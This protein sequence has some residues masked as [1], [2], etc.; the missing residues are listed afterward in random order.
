MLRQLLQ[1]EFLG[2]CLEDAF[3]MLVFLLLIKGV[4]QF[5][6]YGLGQILFKLRKDERNTRAKRWNQLKTQWIPHITTSKQDL[7][8]K[9]HQI[10][11]HKSPQGHFIFV[12]PWW[13]HFL[14][15]EFGNMQSD[16]EYQADF[17]GNSQFGRQGLVSEIVESLRYVSDQLGIGQSVILEPLSLR[18]WA[19]ES[20]LIKQNWLCR[21]NQQMCMMQ[22]KRTVKITIL[23]PL[24]S[25]HFALM[26][27]TQLVGLRIWNQLPLSGYCI[28]S[29]LS[30]S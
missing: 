6:S 12:W 3:T 29:V 1:R 18:I 26:L 23:G 27:G 25:F 9:L 24:V 15:S 11:F 17:R 7:F 28:F 4:G 21:N 16:T 5:R 13:L 19:V 20:S 8:L 10:V 2:G 14:K 30:L 22:L